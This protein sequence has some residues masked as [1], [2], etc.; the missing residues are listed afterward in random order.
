MIQKEEVVALHI[1]QH[2]C[3]LIERVFDYLDNQQKIRINIMHEYIWCSR[4]TRAANHGGVGHVARNCYEA[5]RVGLAQRNSAS[6][7]N[8][9]GCIDSQDPMRYA[10]F[11]LHVLA[12]QP[13]STQGGESLSST[14]S[15]P[16]QSWRRLGSV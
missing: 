12:V 1:S 16:R 10:N 5:V 3:W 9:Y 6:A 13:G 7:G 11:A 8:N 2:I 4:L 15:S 14:K